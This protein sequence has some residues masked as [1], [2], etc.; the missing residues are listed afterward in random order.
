MYL[1]INPYIGSKYK[2]ILLQVSP[3]K[4]GQNG[5]LPIKSLILK[6]KTATAKI[7]LFGKNAKLDYRPGNMLEV[8]GVYPKEYRNVTQLAS[9]KTTKCQVC[10]FNFNF[11]SLLF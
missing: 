4:H 1:N 9:T 2:I 6:D 5:T 11:L 10:N 3:I 7:C 8:S